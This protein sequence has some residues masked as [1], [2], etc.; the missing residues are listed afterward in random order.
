MRIK[1]SVFLQEMSQYGVG[2]ISKLKVYDATLTH[3]TW[4]TL[5]QLLWSQRAI[6]PIYLHQFIN[7]LNQRRSQFLAG[8]AVEG[9]VRTRITEILSSPP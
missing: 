1:R 7:H 5:P 6:A 9:N 8:F 3:P 4:T 2:V